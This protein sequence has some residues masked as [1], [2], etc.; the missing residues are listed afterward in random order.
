MFLCDF[1]AS[2]CDVLLRAALTILF[3]TVTLIKI[4]GSDKQTFS[5]YTTNLVLSNHCVVLL[6]VSFSYNCK[7]VFVVLFLF[8]SEIDQIVHSDV[9]HQLLIFCVIFCKCSKFHVERKI[10]GCLLIFSMSFISGRSLL[11]WFDY[12]SSFQLSMDDLGDDFDDLVDL[13]M[14]IQEE[15]ID[16]NSESNLCIADI[17]P[18]LDETSTF[19]AFSSHAAKSDCLV[20]NRKRTCSLSDDTTNGLAHNSDGGELLAADTHPPKRRRELSPQTCQPVVQLTANA[21]T[22]ADCMFRRL[23]LDRDTISVTGETGSRLYIEL[24]PSPSMMSKSKE[25][26]PVVRP[27]GALLGE[28]LKTVAI[29]SREKRRIFTAELDLMLA[30][31]TASPEMSVTDGNTAAAEELWVDKYA[32]R[33]YTDL[34]SD[35]RTNRSLLRWVK[36]W[37]GCVFGKAVAAAKRRPAPSHDA[38][39]DASEMGFQIDEF[40]RPV[41]LLVLLAGPPGLG[42]TTLAHV[43]ARHA[44]YHIVEMNASDDRAAEIFRQ[45]LDAAV[46]IRGTVHGDQR[47]VCLVVDEADGAPSSR[48]G[49]AVGLRA[50]STL[51]QGQ[52]QAARHTDTATCHLHM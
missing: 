41:P 40:K 27:N 16:D 11:H 18:V 26:T 50:R 24:A 45:R 2:V 37:D 43:V 48:C 44:G 36:A 13:E 29:A 34:L 30:T 6:V 15:K 7:L 8:G 4:R 10:Y 46:S 22:G 12:C 25:F 33:G 51:G 19:A 52:S 47:P 9:V 28:Q 23:P 49:R 20:V 21:A 35:E 32:P 1:F 5:L 17:T 14:E 3:G 31:N 38:W 39:M 42:K